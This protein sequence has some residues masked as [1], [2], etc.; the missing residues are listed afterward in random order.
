MAKCV[1][2]L[3]F[4]ASG[5]AASLADAMGA[6]A[7]AP[8]I[9]MH[10]GGLAALAQE[11]GGTVLYPVSNTAAFAA[12]RSVQLRLETAC[13]L[14]PFLPADPSQCRC[15][16]HDVAPMMADAIAS[17][18]TALAGPG[19]CHQWDVVLRWQAEAVVAARR[20][21]IAN[22]GGGRAGLAA[23]VQ[24]ALALERA[25]REAGLHAAMAQIALAVA[26]AGSRE[27]ETGIT[28][29]LPSGG[30]AALE[31]ALEA[32]P[33]AVSAG[34]SADIRGPLPPLSFAAVRV[35][36]A[37]P[38]ELAQAWQA[39]ALPDGIDEAALK[40]QWHEC[41]GRLHPD[42]GA[43]DHGKM[44]E[45]GAAFRLLRGLLPAPDRSRAPDQSWTLAALQ[46]RGARRLL[47]AAP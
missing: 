46:K 20:D 33:D 31:A 41:A 1:K 7:G 40:R 36:S 14:A 23:A 12:L 38:D 16:Q 42:H 30:I 21:M 47:V 3:G 9:V 37:S 26:P 39:L 8:M 32:L 18:T 17:L 13:Q 43:T 22:A 4:A 27:T 10:A 6:L 11:D 44:A 45:A 24:A 34:A 2:L 25:L 19:R 29:L 15:P 28:V 35:A 5:D